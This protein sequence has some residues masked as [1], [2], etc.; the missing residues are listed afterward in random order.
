MFGGIGMPHHHLGTQQVT[1]PV[2]HAQHHHIEHSGRQVSGLAVVQGGNAHQEHWR[3]GPA[4]AACEAVHAEGMP[5]PGRGHTLV[6]DGEVAGVERR[7]AHA[8][9]HHHQQ[10]AA[11]PGGLRSHQRC[12]QE[13]PDGAK[14]HRA[15]AQAVHHKTRQGL[16]HAGDDK[17]HR[18]E[19]THIGVAQPEVAHEHGEQRR[20]QQVGEVR[21]GVRQPNQPHD[22]GVL[23]EG[24]GGDVG[25]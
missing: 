6:E 7:I 20:Q 24:H 8:R 3:Q 19:K 17:K 21:A 11:V 16:A 5:Q 4:Q 13:Q 10:Q 14:Q 1:L 18:H 9:Q 23:P 22:G 25:A 12:Q 15:C 2:Q